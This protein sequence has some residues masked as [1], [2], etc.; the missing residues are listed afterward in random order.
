MNDIEL[1]HGDYRRVAALAVAAATDNID[2]LVQIANEAEE[3]ERY[4]QLLHAAGLTIAQ[5]MGADTPEGLELL[6]RHVLQL[7]ADE[8]EEGNN[9]V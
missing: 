3:L 4:P 5:G 6:R 9:D 2:S 7:A 1:N 8:T